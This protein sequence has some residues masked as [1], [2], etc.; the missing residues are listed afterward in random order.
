MPKL[1]RGTEVEVRLDSAAPLLDEVLTLEQRRDLFEYPGRTVVAVMELSSVS[2]TG[3]ADT[4][5]KPP[6]VKLRVTSVEAA[7][8]AVEEDALRRAMAA[9]WRAR[10]MDGTLDSIGQGPRQAAP[11]L[12][13]A[14]AGYP[15]DAEVRRAQAAKRTR[16]MHNAPR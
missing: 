2:Y 14:F 9:M 12:D 5:D 1:P 16:D 7:V 4:E 6:R 3:H 15:D 8:T 11:I 10:E 13:E